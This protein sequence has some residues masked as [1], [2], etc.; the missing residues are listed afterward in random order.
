MH[1]WFHILLGFVKFVSWI[2][3]SK[4]F[5][6]FPVD[7]IKRVIFYADVFSAYFNNGQL[8]LRL[9]LHKFSQNTAKLT[10]N[11]IAVFCVLFAF[12]RFLA[13][14]LCVCCCCSDQHHNTLLQ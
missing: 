8:H 12:C 9:V 1:F 14:W 4:V 13:F 3:G 7:F 11:G 2:P 6:T 10:P 5:M